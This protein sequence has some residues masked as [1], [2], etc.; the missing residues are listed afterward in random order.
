MMQ[1]NDF[2]VARENPKRRIT[3]SLEE[4]AF[5]NLSRR[6]F[7]SNVSM[8]WIIRYAV[9]NLL[10]DQKEG[11]VYPPCKHAAISSKDLSS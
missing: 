8:A 6:A 11:L 1:R 5:K 4:D 9:D 3:I 2:L 10:K 7:E